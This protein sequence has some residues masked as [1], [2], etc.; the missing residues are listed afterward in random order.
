MAEAA[1]LALGVVGVAGLYSVVLQV[2]EQISN[3]ASFNTDFATQKTTFN[4]VK[5]S[6]R[7][8]GLGTG[9]A[10]S[11]TLLPDH[12]SILDDQEVLYDVQCALACIN[13]ACAE[14]QACLDKSEPPKQTNGGTGSRARVVK[15]IA[16]A[17][18]RLRWTFQEKTKVQDL[19]DHI[20]CLAGLLFK[21]ARPGDPV[22]L[23]CDAKLAEL[24]SSNEGMLATRIASE[25]G[26]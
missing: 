10:A 15:K 2:V 18:R 22:A 19:I 8:W 21:I 1:G 11:G 5:T 16:S 6:L 20:I 3:A 23:L 24:L 12:S 25:Q 9:L 13:D 7:A 14:L 4:T 26:S 17:G